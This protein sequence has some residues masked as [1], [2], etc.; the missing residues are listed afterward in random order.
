[1]SS[2]RVCI[3]VENT[4]L[5]FS[6]HF[7]PCLNKIWFRIFRNKS[8][9][10]MTMAVISQSTLHLIKTKTKTKVYLTF[11]RVLPHLGFFQQYTAE[12]A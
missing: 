3:D 9:D 2:T 8:A 10:L 6:I 1:M 4:L 7:T 5:I 11:R 12:L